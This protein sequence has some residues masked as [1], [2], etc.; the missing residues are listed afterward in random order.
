[1]SVSSIILDLIVA[2]I[3]VFFAL[4]SAKKGFVRTLVEVV[5]FGAAIILAFNFST[6]VSDFIYDKAIEPSVFKTVNQITDSTE[7]VID[8]TVNTVLDKMPNF[9]TESNYFNI[10][11]TDAV[12]LVKQDT[13]T[14]NGETVLANSIS[15]NVVKP[16]VV[17]LLSLILSIV[18]IAVFIFV[19][20]FLAKFINKIFSI[21][22]IGSLNKF[23]G[24]V[25][26]IVKGV[27]VSLIFCLLISLIL[28]FTKNGFLIFTNESINSSYLF[29]FLMQFINF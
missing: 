26:G 29:K 1:M 17:K 24:A 9:I 6:V 10:S 2:F 20:K 21:S 7:T 13:A 3:V 16:P 15:K 12:D 11:K 14:Q 27:A 28:S 23:L 5:G 18:F 19:V 8:D 22:V 4:L 25:I